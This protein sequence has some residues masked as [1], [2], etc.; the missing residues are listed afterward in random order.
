MSLQSPRVIRRL[1]NNSWTLIRS[2]SSY[3]S[4]GLL[5]LL[6]QINYAA[7]DG[8]FLFL[9]TFV[10]VSLSPSRVIE[11]CLMMQD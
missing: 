1:Y 6:S 7:V 4:S 2:S 11:Q 5:R 10:C 8:W 9:L 3:V